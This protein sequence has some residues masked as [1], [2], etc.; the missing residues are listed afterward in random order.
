MATKRKDGRWVERFTYNGKRY[1]AYGGTKKEA[2]Q[3]ARIKQQELENRAYKKSADL[4][5]D[6]YH[7]RWERARFGTVKEA[8]IRNQ[9]LEYAKASKIVIDKAG[10]TFGSLKIVDIEVQ[11]VRDLQEALKQE[12]QKNGSKRY[13]TRTINDIMNHL[14]HIMN[15]AV[16]ERIITWN[17]FSAVKSLKREE[18]EARNTIHR[19]LSVNETKKFFD[20]AEQSWYYDTFRFMLYSGCRCGEVGALKFS[21]IDYR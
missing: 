9:T 18:D 3:N 7:E 19:A 13:A 17:P 4:T 21:D 2:V 6:Q 20:L 1:A 16:K 15:D 14:K 12:K 8:T 11:N 10:N 5:L